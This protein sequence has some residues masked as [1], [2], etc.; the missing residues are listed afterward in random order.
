MTVPRLV[1]NPLL[2]KVGTGTLV[3]ESLG[4]HQSL[5][6]YAPT[7]V[8]SLPGVAR[9]LGVRSVHVKDESVRLGMPSFKIL[10]ASWAAY[11]VLLRHL[12]S[13]GGRFRVVTKLGNP[14]G[15][16][17]LKAIRETDPSDIRN[18]RKDA[19]SLADKLDAWIEDQNPARKPK[20]RK[21]R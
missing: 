19:E 21:R 18:A 16:V 10:G 11:R 1:P 15:A 3:R 9:Q 5:P 4:F 13:L 17:T 14:V 6:G 12:G 2:N 7:P 20:A 8:R